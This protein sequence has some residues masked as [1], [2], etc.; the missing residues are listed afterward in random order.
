M[1][2]HHNASC[3]EIVRRRVNVMNGISHINFMGYIYIV[4]TLYNIMY[5]N[6]KLS[7][8][9]LTVKRDNYIM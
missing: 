6:V 1:I 7:P 2:V 8:K 4:Y 5:L 9:T 3:N